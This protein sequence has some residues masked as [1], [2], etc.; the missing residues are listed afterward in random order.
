MKEQKRGRRIAM[1]QQELDAFLRLVPNKIVS[2]DF[3]K[4]GN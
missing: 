3:R 1:D 4:I 2:W